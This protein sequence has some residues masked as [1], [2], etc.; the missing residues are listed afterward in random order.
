VGC[1]TGYLHLLE[2]RL[3]SFFRHHKNITFQSAMLKSVN[4]P[5][6]L[7]AMDNKNCVLQEPLNSGSKFHNHKSVVSCVL[8]AMVIMNYCFLFVNDAG[9]QRKISDGMHFQ[10]LY[11]CLGFS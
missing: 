9:C 10:G 2:Y 8:F 6:S 7:E 1:H 3:T 11:I 4:F 5:H